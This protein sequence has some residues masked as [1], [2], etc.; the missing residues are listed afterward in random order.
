MSVGLLPLFSALAALLALLAMVGLT[1]PLWRRA[2]SPNPGPEG[3]P[4]SAALAVLRDEWQ[5]IDR[6]HQLG[7]IDAADW[8]LARQELSRR[9]VAEGSDAASRPTASA[10]PA[11]P[12]RRQLAVL[13]LAVWAVGVAAYLWHGRTDVQALSSTPWTAFSH[14]DNTGSAASATQVES[15]VLDMARELEARAR[16]GHSGADDAGAWELLARALASL[17]RFEEAD[18]AYRQATERDPRNARLLADHADVLRA[19]EGERGTDAPMRLL[20]QALRI[21]PQ[22]PKALALAGRI[23][24][25][26]RDWPRA[27]G[28]WQRAQAVAPPGSD[29]AVGAERGLAEARAMLPQPAARPPLGAP[30]PLAAPASPGAVA[31]TSPA[32]SP[33]TASLAGRVELSPAMRAQAQPNDT[34]FVV[35]R[36]AAPAAGSTELPR[37]PLA[38]VQLRVSDLPAR[39]AVDDRQSMAP[40]LRPSQFSRLTVTARVARG[41]DALPA[42]GD[43]VS[44]AVTAARGD[45]V[46]V[47]RIDRIQR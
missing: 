40:H 46:L 6:A 47:L 26:Q 19:A 11:T 25:E 8:E 20:E 34:V 15:M 29:L 42:S 36:A 45:T 22:Q 4:S 24:Y 2:R 30:Q 9:A 14:A 27:I 16:A 3:S 1:S 39:F 21:D 31:A 33:A 17:Q 23:A 44:D 5:T 37:M 35:V 13:A 18:R 7:E 28:Y 12:P 43:W 38:I 10:L 41:G 32:P